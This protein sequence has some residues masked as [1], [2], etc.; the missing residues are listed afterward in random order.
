MNMNVL[1]G[2]GRFGSK[3]TVV[4]RG[5]KSIKNL[6]EFSSAWERNLSQNSNITSRKVKLDG[7]S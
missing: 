2:T 1:S 4:P 6:K 5:I 3:D 7:L